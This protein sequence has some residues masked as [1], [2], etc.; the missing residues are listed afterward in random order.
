[1]KSS[2]RNPHIEYLIFYLCFEVFFVFMLFY[3]YG[4]VS[5]TIIF[6]ICN[7]LACG[8]IGFHIRLIIEFEK[9]RK[10]CDEFNKAMEELGKMIEREEI[11]EAKNNL[12]EE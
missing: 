12:Y 9:K 7:M 3:T 6:L 1:M 5:S 2:P 11:E 8:V 10:F 4:D